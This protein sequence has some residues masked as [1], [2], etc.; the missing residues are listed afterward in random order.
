[1][2]PLERDVLVKVGPHFERGADGAV[3]FKFVV[4]T[5]NVV[6]PRKATEADKAEHAEAWARFQREGM[7]APEP[8]AT[9]LADDFTAMTAG[10]IDLSAAVQPRRRG[11][12]PKVA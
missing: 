4:D 8:L 6:G 3:L 2:H 1:M 12:P 5:S 10:P 7:V 11:R 9:V